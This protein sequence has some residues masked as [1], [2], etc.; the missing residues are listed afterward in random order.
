[1][2]HYR[3]SCIMKGFKRLRAPMIIPV[4]FGAGCIVA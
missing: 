4:E 1:M 2:L 3:G